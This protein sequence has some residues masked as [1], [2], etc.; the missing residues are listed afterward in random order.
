MNENLS[1]GEWFFRSVDEFENAPPDCRQTPD[2]CALDAYLC[3]SGQWTIGDGC[4]FWEDGTPVKQGDRL[5]DGPGLEER[6]KSL[7]MYNAHYCEEY[8]REHVTVPLTQHQ[9]DAL[10]DFRFNTRETTL[11][12]ST[13]LLPAI[14]G[15]EWQKAAVAFTEFVYGTTTFDGKTYQRAM[16]G[17]LRRRLWNGLVFLGYDPSEA[18][19]EDDVALPADRK[20]LSSGVYRDIIRSEGVT[21]LNQVRMKATQLVA[22]ATPT[23]AQNTGPSPP[24]SRPAPVSPSQLPTG[25]GAGQSNAKEQPPVLKPA[26]PPTTLPPVVAGTGGVKPPH[27]ETKMPEGIPYGIDPTAGAKPM[28]TTERFIGAAMLW[29]ANGLR[30]GMANGMKLSGGLGF[31]TVLFL[32]MMKSPVTAAVMLSSIVA[33]VCFVGWLLGIGLEKAGLRKK[34]RGEARASQLMY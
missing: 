31:V 11:R 27:R 6:R 1:V 8:I 29:L 10:C 34:K 30:V 19:K 32:D 26:G 3:P 23:P 16:R 33:A 13:R 22:S 9:F 24:V 17:L 20:L 18:V 21:T 15:Q 7:L 12:N 5:E 25:A 4:C 14:N 28:E 2:G